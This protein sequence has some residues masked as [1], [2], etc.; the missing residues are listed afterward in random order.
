MV[1]VNLHSYDR[2]RGKHQREDTIDVVYKSAL[3]MTLASLVHVVKRRKQRRKMRGDGVFAKTERYSVL[4]LYADVMH[5]SLMGPASS[6]P[7]TPGDEQN[8]DVISARECMVYPVV[9]YQCAHFL[10]VLR[11]GA[12][13]S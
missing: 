4:L 6:S 11:G 2:V 3:V 8:I 12:R 1:I 5:H 9:Y 7:N 13:A 10:L